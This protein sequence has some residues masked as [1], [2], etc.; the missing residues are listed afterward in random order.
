MRAGDILKRISVSTLL[1]FAL[2]LFPQLPAYAHS[3]N[4]QPSQKAQQKQAKKY[5]KKQ[6]KAEKKE[7]KKQ[8]KAA[9][10]WNKGRPHMTT[11]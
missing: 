5:N 6:A 4:A 9:K 7:M 8:N 11:T 3:H 10:K 1:L 2:M